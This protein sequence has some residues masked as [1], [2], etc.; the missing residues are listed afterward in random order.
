MVKN[1]KKLI[2]GY[3][4]LLILG[5]F[6][7]HNS[8]NQKEIKVEDKKEEKSVEEVKP[9]KVTLQVETTGYV[10]EYKTAMKNTDSI[11]ELLEELRMHKGFWYEKTAYIY[12]TE[13]DEIN[14]MKAPLDSKWKVFLD[15]QDITFDIAD[16]KLEDGKVYTIRLVSTP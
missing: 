13:I 7:V 11:L 3:I 4:G 8:L 6:M 14:H 9:V 10:T 15:E 5:A 12:G 1:K 16:M 2:L